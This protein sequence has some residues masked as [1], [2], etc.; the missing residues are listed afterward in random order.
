MIETVSSFEISKIDYEI[1]HVVGCSL[2]DIARDTLSNMFMNTD[3][4]HILFIDSDISWDTKAIKLLLDNKHLDI[5]GGIYPKKKI[6]NYPI[7]SSDQIGTV[8]SSIFCPLEE[9]NDRSSP[10]KV[11]H[12]PAGFM[13][14]SKNVFELMSQDKSKEYYT[15][16]GTKLVSFF[17]CE[18]VDNDIDWP[19][20]VKGKLH[21]GEDAN[22]CRKARMLGFSCYA[23][24]AIGLSHTGDINYKF[25]I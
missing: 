20:N 23:I 12:L 25:K 22:F 19:K 15:K 21:Y 11:K 4:T 9:F 5:V 6:D 7:Y 17:S 8:D 10:V 14:I 24:P 3:C 13:L 18:L 1:H 16:D 2:I